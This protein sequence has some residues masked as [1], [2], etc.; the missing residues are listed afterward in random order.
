MKKLCIIIGLCLGMLITEAEARSWLAIDENASGKSISKTIA[1]STNNGLV[2]EYRIHGLNLSEST[3]NGNSFVQPYFDEISTLS[4]IGKPALPVISQLIALP[5]ASTYSIN[6]NE[7]EWEDVNMGTILPYQKP[8]LENETDDKFVMSNETYSSS[9]FSPS[10]VSEG[11]QQTW[12]G[13]KNVNVS[14]CPFKYY[15]QEGR[16]AVLKKF[17]LIVNFTKQ[18]ENNEV[19]QQKVTSINIQKS[20]PNLNLF[21]NSIMPDSHKQKS[22]LTESDTEEYDYLIIAGN[23]TGIL[24]STALNK[25]REWK[26]CKGYKT[27]VVSTSETGTTT[28]SIKNYIYQ[29]YLK[30]VKYVVFI[31]D[32]DKIPMKVVN[33]P[34]GRNVKSDY[35]YGC[36]DGES[37]YEADVCM[38]R[39]PTNSLS[40]FSNMVT[41]TIKYEI[42]PNNNNR[43]L[44]VAN[45]QDA[46]GKYQGCLETIRTSSYS[47]PMSFV[48][49]YGATSS[50]GG[51]SST[52]ATLLSNI[53]NNPNIVNYR[54]HGGY[55]HWWSWN[56]LQ[57]SFYSSQLSN[58]ASNT[59]SIYFS[60]ACQTG[61]IRNLTCMME[62][63]LRSD[64]AAVAFI[65]AT[66]D[67]YTTPNHT[68]NKLMFQKMLN[69][70]VYNV[71]DILLYSHISNIPQHSSLAIDNAFCY[72]C[73]GDPTLEVWTS[74]P[75]LFGGV[76][77][78]KDGSS[79]NILSSDIE[80]YKTCVVENSDLV[81]KTATQYFN[82]SLPLPS[83]N[84]RI[85]LNKH[86]YIPYL[87]DYN[88]SS[89]YIQN[90]TY[91][92]NSYFCNTPISIGYDVTDEE[93]YGNVTIETGTTLIIEKGLGVTI[94]NG[95]ECKQGAEFIIQ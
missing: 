73:G 74:V 86:D 20:I 36:M 87:I 55:N 94:K 29:E 85:S 83:F 15:P 11:I 78:H 84:C 9:V 82:C 22:N 39:F 27:K 21:A 5:D 25:L 51:N 67:S 89:N 33:S 8:L 80:N 42:S 47:N 88:I 19:N 61:N 60:I 92:N 75:N 10:I 95:F 41:K 24:Q 77:F 62:T 6:I 65:G 30:G 93:A 35:W 69:G 32:D 76:E 23:I 17:T 52:N 56:Y 26:S 28:S 58:M 64:R 4:E 45:Y 59:N 38:G 34:M 50:Y 16:L 49:I 3:I 31:G 43:T 57:E 90:A 71:G 48:P 46:P 1:T 63:F 81:Y 44:L 70:G 2:I 54:G 14:I 7:E 37:D 79:L 18:S 40:E 72:I 13:I 91:Q 68:L 66:E 12:R 53:N